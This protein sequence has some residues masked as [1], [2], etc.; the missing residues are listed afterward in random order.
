MGAALGIVAAA[1]SALDRIS[2]MR[3]LASALEVNADVPLLVLL[4]SSSCADCR[5]LATGFGEAAA[6]AP[7]ARFATAVEENDISTSFGVTGVPHVLIFRGDSVWELAADALAVAHRNRDNPSIRSWRLPQSHKEAR[8]F[9]ESLAGRVSKWLDAG[10]APVGAPASDGS[11]TAALAV[12]FDSLSALAAS[13]ASLRSSSMS[14]FWWR[15]ASSFFAFI[16]AVLPSS[17][18]AVAITASF[19]TSGLRLEISSATAR[20]TAV[21]LSTVS[22]TVLPFS[23]LADLGVRR[24]VER[25]EREAGGKY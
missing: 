6:L 3:A 18:D 10:G 1:Q 25:K 20:S 11:A 14:S 15:S 13:S 16:S 8:L 17:V 24:R 2:D 12:S 23:T 9:A 4:T 21:C 19:T 22:A 5:F 7:R